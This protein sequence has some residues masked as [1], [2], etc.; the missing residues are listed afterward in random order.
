M[1]RDRHR[2][3]AVEVVR[4]KVRECLERTGHPRSGSRIVVAMSG[5]KDSF[6]MAYGLVKLSKENDWEVVGAHVVVETEIGEIEA[7]DVVEEQADVLGIDVHVLKPSKTVEEAA[8]EM[9][10]RKPCYACRTLRRIELGRFSEDIGADY[11]ALGHTLDDAAATVILSLLTGAPRIK[12]LGYVGSGRKPLLLRPLVRCPE[13]ITE[14]LVDEIGV[15]TMATEEV[16]PYKSG[17][18][19]RDIVNEFLSE[20]ERRIPTVKG[21]IVG[22]ALRT[23]SGR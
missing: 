23:I 9:K 17:E 5:G 13:E 18:E 8:E 11:I 14:R 10:A 21:N 22:T 12:V 6:A 20:V 7:R 16:C 15:N 4:R 3:R 2:R 19:L 1:Q